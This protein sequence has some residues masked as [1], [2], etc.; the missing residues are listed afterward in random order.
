MGGPVKLYVY[1]LR[2]AKTGQTV[3]AE[4]FTT[5]GHLSHLY[6]HLK[7][8][9]RVVSIDP[10]PGFD[11]GVLPRDVLAMI[12]MGKDSWETHVPEVVARV[13]KER[14]LFGYKGPAVIA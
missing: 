14:R 7:E 13:I 12:R 8:N 4:T 6:A 10:G 11:A 9:G 3:T 2:N 5:P 1:P